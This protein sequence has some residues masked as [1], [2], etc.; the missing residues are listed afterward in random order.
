MLSNVRSHLDRF[1]DGRWRMIGQNRS[2]AVYR[3]NRSDLNI[4]SIRCRMIKQY[5]SSAFYLRCRLRSLSSLGE[6][7][8][9]LSDLSSSKN[10]I[11]SN[12]MDFLSSFPRPNIGYFLR[13]HRCCYSLRSN[14]S[15]FPPGECVTERA[16][17]WNCKRD[18]VKEIARPPSHWPVGRRWVR[19]SWICLRLHLFE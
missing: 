5:R 16:R 4:F 1:K 14:D 19:S 6:S 7:P 8:R 13:F 18:R 17:W 10:R 3:S 2:G 12:E 15:V 11:F 9:R